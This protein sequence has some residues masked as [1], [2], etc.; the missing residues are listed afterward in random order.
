MNMR[1]GK[2][3]RQKSRL[4]RVALLPAILSLALI[5]ALIRVT[6]DY[7]TTY[8]PKPKLVPKSDGVTFLPIVSE[9]ELKI[10]SSH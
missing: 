5:Y 9:K 10:T 3:K 6:V 2:V 7:E 8:K 1:R 4:L